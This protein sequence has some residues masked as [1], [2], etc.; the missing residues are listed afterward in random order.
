MKKIVFLAVAMMWVAVVLGQRPMGDTVI[1]PDSTYYPYI[2]NWCT[3][4]SLDW[5]VWTCYN[6]LSNITRADFTPE[7]DNPGYD[8]PVFDCRNNYCH[9]NGIVGLQ[10]KTDRPIKI[11]GIAAPAYMEAARD[12]TINWQGGLLWP[13]YPSN[14]KFLNTR[15]TTLAGRITDSMMLYQVVGDSLVELMAKGWRMDDPH[16]YI[17]LPPGYLG[18]RVNSGW[19]SGRCLNIYNIYEEPLWDSSLVLPLYE[20]MFEK[21]VVVEDSFV[22]AGAFYNNEGHIQWQTL[23]QSEQGEMMWLWDH[24]PTRYIIFGMLMDEIDGRWAYW[25][26]FRKKEWKKFGGHHVVAADLDEHIIPFGNAP[27]IFPI[28]EPG[29]DTTL[30]HNVRDIRVVARTDSSATLCWD[31]GDG[32]PWEVAFGKMTDQ[33]EDFTITT[34]NTPMVTLTGLEAGTVYFA[35][36]RSYCGVTHEYGDWSSPEEVEIYEHHPEPEGIAE[37]EGDR[38]VYLMPN[39]ARG[40]VSVMSSY[41]I[42]RMEVYDMTGAKVHEERV[43]GIAA[44]VDV[45]GWKRGTYVVAL[46]L[47]QGVVTKKLLVE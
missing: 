10:M 42:G 41:R 34:V 2:Y 32:G 6:H 25:A 5:H 12:T 22:V 1:C 17:H 28:I 16:R 27:F 38:M 19:L 11:I 21:P 30:C 15:D 26:K 8:N 47:E 35:L 39:P 44:N 18:C 46:Y 9:G 31:S 36:V 43:D 45:S 40:V 24:N 13:E 7:G 4:D 29:F 23:P 20:V 37:K 33:W 3:V 14:R